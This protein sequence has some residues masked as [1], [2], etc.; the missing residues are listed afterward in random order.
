M[1]K[2]ARLRI[3]KK[4]KV[5]IIMG[6]Q[7]AETVYAA[8]RKGMGAAALSEE[9]MELLTVKSE[10]GEEDP[11]EPEEYSE[12]QEEAARDI[13][14]HDPLFAYLHEIGRYHLLGKK[15]EAELGLKID[16]ESEEVR[17]GTVMTACAAGEIARL[18]RMCYLGQLTARGGKYRFFDVPK[19]DV[20][21]NA[22]K[23]L[24]TMERTLPA[25]RQNIRRVMTDSLSDHGRKEL[26]KE[27]GDMQQTWRERLLP[28]EPSYGSAVKPLFRM[29]LHYKDILESI[30]G[31]DLPRK[32]AECAQL[33]IASEIGD[34][35]ESFLDSMQEL[36]RFYA[37]AEAARE[38]LA[39][40]NLRLVVSIA[41]NYIG[42]GLDFQDIIQ[43]G[44][45]GLLRAVEKFD[46]TLGFKFSTYATWWIKQAIRR[47][48][49]DYSRTIR[50]PTHVYT[51]VSQASRY[52]MER[53]ERSPTV[54]EIAEAAG[55]EVDHVNLVYR[56]P[57][58]LSR[59]LSDDGDVFGDL[60][61][62]EDT[63]DPSEEVL[64]AISTEEFLNF[65]EGLPYDT[66]I[67]G[68]NRLTPREVY[69]LKERHGINCGKRTLV[70]VGLDL[71]ICRERVRQIQKIATRKLSYPTV[72][73]RIEALFPEYS[74][75]A[76]EK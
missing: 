54:K 65:L 34:I 36:E 10:P 23:T 18:I 29:L 16:T 58:A 76:S 44:N 71:D 39:T 26:I 12:E 75:L 33:D 74:H 50:V 73:R 57:L 52:L 43:Y 63:P 45:L 37:E 4:E 19:R 17:E 25:A 27:V 51:A 56:R 8:S 60:L 46:Y 20:L 7:D 66:N 61:A 6:S 21:R 55:V 2:K 30:A 15:L 67:P 64:A 35:P 24:E 9:D 68:C 1:E 59:P 11:E 38:E 47:A 3:Y 69:V 53:L 48:L 28:V 62:D 5:K 72:E 32:K 49:S 14:V 42:R 22:P 13:A 40:G 31:M 70:E 41:K